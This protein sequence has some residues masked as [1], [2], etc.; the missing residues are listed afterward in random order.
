MLAIFVM[1]ATDL[2]G[3]EIKKICDM[4]SQTRKEVN[5]MEKYK[6]IVRCQLIMGRPITDD[7]RKALDCYHETPEFCVNS[8]YEDVEIVDAAYELFC[9]GKP[10]FRCTESVEL[11]RVA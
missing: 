1:F 2:G 10:E 7:D 8:G 4:I 9:A 6:L 5:N 11:V 3:R